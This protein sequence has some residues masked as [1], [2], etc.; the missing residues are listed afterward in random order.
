M[1]PANQADLGAREGELAASK[2]T[3]DNLSRSSR[4]G[5]Q[6]YRA[7]DAARIGDA[8]HYVHWQLELIESCL[9]PMSSTS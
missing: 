7:A 4:G 9:V 1:L 8:I 3:H 6:L 5:S 2:L